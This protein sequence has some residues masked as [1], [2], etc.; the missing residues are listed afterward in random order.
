MQ[1]WA[2]VL[3]KNRRT[4]EKILTLESINKDHLSIS[5]GAK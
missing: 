4:A 2:Y 1:V 5:V 3:A